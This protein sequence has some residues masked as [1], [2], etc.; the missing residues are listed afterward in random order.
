LSP[1]QGRVQR[2]GRVG[3]LSAFDGDK[4]PA[5][6]ADKSAHS[7]VVAA[8]PRR[9]KRK[10]TADF[11]GGDVFEGLDGP[12]GPLGAKL[13][14]RVAAGGHREDLRPDG[15]GALDVARGVTNDKDLVALEVVPQSVASPG[16]SDACEFV[17]IL[18]V[19]TKSAGFES[20]PKTKMAQF[21]AGAEADVAGQQS[22]QRRRRSG[23]Q[24]TEP[25][26]DAGE[27]AAIEPAHQMFQMKDVTI[28]E[29]PKVLGAGFDFMVR[30]EI[31]HDGRVRAPGE[32]K[33]ER[34]V[35]DAEFSPADFGE[36][37]F[38]CASRGDQGTVNIEQNQ[39]NHPWRRR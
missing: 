14:E 24:G 25:G 3:R 8:S 12:L 28:E 38:P 37:P 6:S 36:S 15:P 22:E 5:E 16:V 21:D 31:P 34:A 20:V 9:E 26:V 11:C 1:K 35:E 17:S 32:M 4:S 29:P 30:E 7:K 18:M 27:H 33:P 2:L 13:V 10:S 19:V 23:A 39:P